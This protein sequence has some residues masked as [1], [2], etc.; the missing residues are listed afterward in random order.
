MAN[1]AQT[2]NVLQAMILTDKEKMLLTPTYHVYEMYTVHQ[3]AKLLLSEVQCADYVLGGDKI[4]GVNV[5]ASVDKAGKIHITLCNLNP[6]SATEVACELRGATAQKLSGRVL[7][8]PEMANHNTFEKPESVKPVAV[9]GLKAAGG[10]FAVTLP[11]KSVM[12]LEV[13]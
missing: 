6:N 3:D 10:G 2:I 8:A 5:S 12:V 7:T 13:N 11:S 1:I 9:D 4:P